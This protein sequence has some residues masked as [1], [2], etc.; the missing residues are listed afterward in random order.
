MFDKP[1][2]RTTALYVSNMTITTIKNV[3]NILVV[4][5]INLHLGYIRNLSWIDKQILEIL[6]DSNYAQSIKNRIGK[7]SEYNVI[8]DFDALSAKSFH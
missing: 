6:V 3:K 5:S 8:S 1:S 2:F 4:V 7:N